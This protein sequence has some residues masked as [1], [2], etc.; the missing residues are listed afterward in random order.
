MQHDLQSLK[1]FVA[2]C[3]TKS[4]TRAAAMT[5][6]AISAASR[7]IKLLEREAGEALV[8]RLPHGVEPTLSGL[9]A[10]RYARSVLRLN[11]QFAAHMA[12]HRSGARGRVRVF[13]SSS[14]LPGFGVFFARIAYGDVVVQGLCHLRQ[15]ARQLGG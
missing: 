4:L 5:N 1:L 6:I 8:R 9:T 7:R 14:A 13:A 11:D 3:E 12:E 10:L 15:I 2:L